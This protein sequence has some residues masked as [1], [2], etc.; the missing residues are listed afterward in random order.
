MAP[1]PSRQALPNPGSSLPPRDPYSTNLRRAS[2]ILS[3]SPPSGSLRSVPLS[4]SSSGG[5]TTPNMEHSQVE[6]SP[7]LN[8]TEQ[9]HQLQTSDGQ[10]V[11]PEIFGKIDKGFFLADNDWT[12]YRRNYFALNCSFTLHPAVQNNVSVF[13]MQNHGSVQVHGWALSIAAVVDG[14]DGK[15]ID[16]VQH[17]PKR[18]KG[19]QDKPPRV[20]VQPRP[21]QHL[22]AGDN[23][24]GSGP[25]G[26]YD[27]GF[28]T[29][30]NQ[31]LLEATF[32][33]IQFKCATANNGKRRAAQQYYHLLVELFADVGQHQPER[34][35]KV[36]TRM[37]APMVVRG[38][39]P[40]HYQSERRASNATTGPGG[41]GGGGS[42]QTGGSSRLGGDLSMS[43]NS[44]MLSSQGYGSSYGS[45]QAH[46]YRPSSVQIPMEPVL[47]AEEVK[48]I[49]ETPGYSYYPS[50]MYEGHD[51][52]YTPTPPTSSDVKVKSEF[53]SGYMLPSLTSGQDR[54]CGRWEGT[55]ET[56]GY[57][58]TG[59]ALLQHGLTQ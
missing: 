6:G 59:P 38:R 23:G 3:R 29:A 26:L 5:F 12:C 22:Y 8:P 51:T 30:P 49:V 44:S 14:I 37:S 40:G 54:L 32:E 45:G 50:A 27:Q 24:L 55:S 7:P 9:I 31:P 52:R 28:G 57:F 19:P 43:G 11:R 18:D 1:P 20:P 53:T 41:A 47:S 2:E 56:R 13:L 46:H 58:P 33:R 16:L 4:P 36:A 39:S 42:Y 48:G 15:P 34:W 21:H 35:V 10:V 25:R 17:T